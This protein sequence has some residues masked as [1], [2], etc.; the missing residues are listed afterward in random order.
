MACKICW[1]SGGDGVCKFCTGVGYIELGC[2]CIELPDGGRMPCTGKHALCAG[3]GV[4]P[5]QAQAEYCGDCRM[6]SEHNQQADGYRDW[7]RVG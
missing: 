2:V 7:E 1:L 5:R 4:Q 6:D 3:C